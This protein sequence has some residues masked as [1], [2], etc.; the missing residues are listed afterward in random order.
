[1]ALGNLNIIINADASSFVRSMNDASIAAREGMSKSS[2]A[3]NAFQVNTDQRSADVQAAAQA[4]GQ[5]MREAGTTMADVA[6]QTQQSMQAI[7]SAV[8]NVQFESVS[9]KIAAAAGVGVGAGYVAV[10]SWVKKTEEWVTTR[11]QI[12]G[13]AIVAGVTVAAVTGIYLAYKAASAAVGFVEGLFTGDS[14]KSKSIDTFIEQNNKITELQNSLQ[15]TAVQA[16]ATANAMSRIGVS[17]ED[18]A[19]TFEKARA[20]MRT[21]T[22]ELDRLG[23]KYKD[24]NG[25]LLETDTFL[26]NAKTKLGEYTDGWDRNQAAAAMGVGSYAAINEALK[27]SREEIQQS[28]ARL[29]DYNLGIGPESQAAAAAYQ[30]SMRVF[31]DELKLTGDGFSRAWS[32]QIMPA[33]TDLADF[34]KDGWPSAVNT[35]RYGMAT[36]T[37]LFYVFKD[38]VYAASETIL[39]SVESIGAALGGVGSASAAVMRGDFAGA[40]KALI[41]GWEDSKTRLGQIGDNIVAQTMHNAAAMKLAWALD[42][43]TDASAAGNADSG[44]K[45]WVPKPQAQDSVAAQVSEYDKLIATIN[46]KIAATSLESDQ[47]TKL[48][49]AQKL[50]VHAMEVMLTAKKQ[51]TDEEK[52][53]MTTRLE[54]YIALS[55]ETNA[56]IEADKVIKNANQ[57]K[58]ESLAQMVFEQSLWGKNAD[59]IARLTAVRNI[60]AKAQKEIAALEMNEVLNKDAVALAN[61][62]KATLAQADADKKAA[63]AKLQYQQA[64]QGKALGNKGAQAKESYEGQQAALDAY[65]AQNQDFENYAKARED[66]ERAHRATL[67]QLAISGDLTQKQF[68]DMSWKDK[69][70]AA[71]GWLEQTT[72]QAAEHSKAMFNMS[73]AAKL[74]QAALEL[75]STVMDAYAWGVKFGGPIG[76][77]IAAGVAGA[78]QLINMRAIASADFGGSYSSASAGGGSVSASALPGQTTNSSVS[79]AAVPAAIPTA[80]PAPAQQPRILNLI[81]DSSVVGNLSQFARQIIPE[82]NAAHADGYTLNGV[83]A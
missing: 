1:M 45:T 4:M 48:T 40:Q 57:A 25:R 49:E 2:E 64:I 18:Y 14:Y 36:A 66:L 56:R 79:A 74:A 58:D 42:N 80:I 77:T 11:L 51:F 70:S 33:L 72:G 16:S 39:G 54:T 23:V 34:F 52:R 81:I 31:N 29:D 19:G 83:A 9:E 15:L 65:A 30:K 12:M 21:N 46:E 55:N 32:D 82:L 68:D 61:A 69:F 41:G 47:Q 60:D 37:T 38:G 26:T 24:Q 73:K 8:N 53:E 78:A 20:A 62:T 44:N 28:K 43:R 27:V 22:E 59:E 76:G 63:L 75:P 67:V 5:N 50:A 35:F 6:A 71:A 7:G 10:E 17:K 13:I 3:V